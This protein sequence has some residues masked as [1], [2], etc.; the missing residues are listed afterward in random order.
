MLTHTLLHSH[1]LFQGH[2][3]KIGVL[4][5]VYLVVVNLTLYKRTLTLGNSFQCLL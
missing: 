2:I 1:D 4:V 3:T 5:A